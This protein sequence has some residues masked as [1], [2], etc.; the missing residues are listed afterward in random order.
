MVEGIGV[1]SNLSA[2]EIVDALKRFYPNR[3]I[4]YQSFLPL[5]TLKTMSPTEVYVTKIMHSE[6]ESSLIA[7]IES[8]QKELKTA[9]DNCRKC[10]LSVQALHQQQQQLYDEFVLLRQKYDEQKTSIVTILWQQCCQFHPD[11]RQIPSI[12]QETDFIENEDVVGNYLLGFLFIL[13][14]LLLLLLFKIT[15]YKTRNIYIFLKKKKK[16]FLSL[17]EIIIF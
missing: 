11:L 10:T 12:E 8:K 9:E 13:L 2:Q 15:H 14:L 6:N 7:K 17:K 16:N 4:K 3:S 1:Y 5:Q